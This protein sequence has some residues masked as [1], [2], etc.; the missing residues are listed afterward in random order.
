MQKYL[1]YIIVCLPLTSLQSQ[2]KPRIYQWALKSLPDSVKL[3][4]DAVN[5]DSSITITNQS[6]KN[7]YFE[8]KKISDEIPFEKL[9]NEQ[10]II[11][12]R[13]S[14]TLPLYKE[15]KELGDILPLNSTTLKK[16]HVSETHGM[17]LYFW[18]LNIDWCGA[19]PCNFS[20]F[21]VVD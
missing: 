2:S 14:N 21:K 4:I 12:I 9:T 19:R 20:M 7:L 18:E 17:G 5:W 6:F 3:R 15:F 13:I 1:F 16:F 8:Y 11:L 10:L